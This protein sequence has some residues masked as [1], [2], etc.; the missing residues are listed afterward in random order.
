MHAR[1]HLK[2]L[3]YSDDIPHFVLD[4]PKYLVVFGQTLRATGC[5]S[6]DLKL[7]DKM[8]TMTSV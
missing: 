5:P 2:L 7:H 3:H 8:C 4:L 1:P 6:L